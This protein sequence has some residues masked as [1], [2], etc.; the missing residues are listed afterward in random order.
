MPRRTLVLVLFALLAA[1]D[2]PGPAHGVALALC[3]GGGYAP[4]EAEA[5]PEVEDV[6]PG[7]PVGSTG[8]G[9]CTCAHTVD[10]L[11]TGWDGEGDTD[12]EWGPGC[13]G[14][15]SIRGLYGTMYWSLLMGPGGRLN[16]LNDWLLYRKG[17]TPP[18]CFN[19]FY[20]NL[21]NQVFAIRVYGDQHV[22]VM[23]GDVDISDQSVGASSFGPSPN[24]S[25]PHAIYE[26]SVPT[27]P[28]GAF[29]ICEFDPDP[30]NE[31]GCDQDEKLKQEPTVVR[32]F[33]NTDGTMTVESSTTAPNLNA[34][35]TWRGSTGDLVTARG[36]NLGPAGT[37]LVGQARAV[38][39]NWSPGKVSFRV[40]LLA[41]GS[42]LV[43]LLR[44]DGVATTPVRFDLTC[45]GS[46][47][48]RMC[49][50]DG[51]GGSCGACLGSEACV[52]GQCTCK[53]NCG[54]KVCGDDGCGGSCGHCHACDGKIDDSICQG[55]ACFGC[56]GSCDGKECGGDGCGGFCGTC[57][58]GEY[59]QAGTCVCQPQCGGK[60]CGENGCGGTCGTCPAGMECAKN[61]QCKAL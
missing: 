1:C 7:E 59:C 2:Q 52:N 30:E 15:R 4:C 34:L 19:L 46:C 29:S 35:S 9:T 21:S 24:D 44:D 13:C 33:I 50:D 6:A 61:G 45:A 54:G 18:N 3:P 42:Y 25:M 32:G 22:T 27:Q 51:C 31:Q 11:F 48:G 17:P 5:V 53:P 23:A 49:G 26:F 39:T 12:F 56:C 40:P 14:F 57:P 20:W 37:V 58:A 43:S 55:G 60:S 47:T 38:V 36:V 8:W 28:L 41:S 16:F 10:G